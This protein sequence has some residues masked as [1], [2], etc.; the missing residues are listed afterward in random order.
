MKYRVVFTAMSVLLFL[1]GCAPAQQQTNQ[2]WALGGPEVSAAQQVVDSS[3][4]ASNALAT[5]ANVASPE[6]GLVDVLINRLGVNTEQAMGGVGSIFSLAQQRMNPEDFMRLSSSVPGVDQYL[7][8]VPE[9]SSSNVFWGSAANMLDGDQSGLGNL[10]GLM[11]SFQRLGMDNTMISEFVPV[12]L[13]Y[14]Q[15]Q[16]GPAAMSLLQNALY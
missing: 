2:N 1:G 6:M 14:V 9:P 7:A 4:M 11:G 12:V 5:A 15:S 13:Q 3:S 10:V 8:A 16:S